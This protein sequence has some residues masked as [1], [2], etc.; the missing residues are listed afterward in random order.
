VGCVAAVALSLG[1]CAD[2]DDGV[3]DVAE[4]NA[5][6]GDAPSGEGAASTSGESTASSGD[7]ATAVTS[8]SPA[9]GADGGTTAP[10]SIDPYLEGIPT[11]AALAVV[12]ELAVI[13]AGAT[14]CGRDAADSGWPT[15]TTGGPD[16]ADCLVEALGSGT[17]AAK[18]I[19]GRD[20]V[21]GALVT[22]YVVEPPDG[23]HVL[24]HHIA[25]DGSVATSE[26]RCTPTPGTWF[27]GL[28][29]RVE[30]DGIDVCPPI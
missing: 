23:L 27:I 20:G 16:D 24:V 11:H 28:E 1:A 6:G 30:V 7:P 21:G 14:D 29:G 3:A 4:L 19:T 13:P 8:G 25:L 15:T 5:T 2:D 12:D 22:L 18:V 17:A 9:S 26:R 10:G